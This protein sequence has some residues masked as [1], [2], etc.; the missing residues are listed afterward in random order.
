MQRRAPVRARWRD[1][2][3][4][5]IGSA[6]AVAA[7]ACVVA[8]ARPWAGEPSGLPADSVGLIGPSGE[9]VGGPVSVGSPA[10][11]AYGDGSVWA[12]DSADGTLARIDPA[13][14]AVVQQI[15]VGSAPS[16]VAVT[17]PDAWVTNSGD[18]TVSRVSTVTDRVVDTIQVGNLPVAIAAGSGGVWV[19]NEGDDT[20][21][22]IDPATGDV[23]KR[24][25]QVGAR[26]DGIAAGPDAVWVANGEDGTVQRIDPATGQPG[27]PVHV[28]SGPEGIAVTPGAVWVANSLDLTV[29]KLDPATGTVT[30]TIGVG[31]GPSSIVAAGNSLWVSDEFDATL[32]RIDP[33]AAPGRPHGSPGKLAAGHGGGRV[34]RMGRRAAVHRGQPPRRHLDRRGLRICLQTDPALA[35]DFIDFELFTAY[36]GLTAFRRSGGAA[37]LT[38]VP[39]LATTLP[40]PTAGGTTYTFT[41]RRG[42]RYSNGNLVRAS[43]FRR[44]IQRQL[45][46]GNHPDYYEGILGGSACRQHPKRCD[47]SAGI[48]TD[49]AAGRVTFRL[50]QADPDFLYKLA[51]INVSPAPPGTPD[52]AISRAPFL[53]G[54]GPYMISQVRPNKSFTLVRN[55]YFRQWSYAAQPAGYPSVIRHE[56]VDSQSAQESAVIAGRG[57]LAYLESSDLQSLAIRYPARV[58]FGLKNGTQYASLNTRQPPFTNLK[59]RQAVNYAIDRARILQL[60]HFASGQATVTC[61]M[62]P[63]DFPG[64]QG[65]CPYTTGA[66]DGAWHGPD[67]EKARRLVRE[68]GTMNMP[69]TV[70]S[71]DDRL[72]KAAGSYLVGL[73]DDLGYRARLHAVSPDQFCTDIYNP[74]LTIQVSILGGWGADY[75]APSTFFGPLLSCQSAD[76]PGTQNLAR[77]CDPHVDAL[78]SQAQAAQL[79]DPAAARRLW[80]QADHIVTD[81]APYVPVLN[82]GTAGFVS[83]RVGNYQESPVYGLL[84]DQMWVR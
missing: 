46:F 18:G 33:Q 58:Y 1:R 50:V 78:A 51:L 39:D 29:S 68:S 63:P 52:R 57:D 77:F 76:E 60:F 27:G 74:R 31:D 49:D 3:L 54:T 75:P 66:G 15:P 72:G 34:R 5:V 47:L 38:L 28:G 25:I 24:G 84:V 73:L 7:A 11:L 44:G 69:V 45:S 53:P 37:G 16:A 67:M 13:T 6:L 21:D 2:R 61:Q 35:D 71:Q 20:V 56:Q 64:H 80:A 12:V 36:D 62:L 48:V 41:L 19:A 9:R 26:P 42:I 30:A 43:D 70:W 81:Q 40:R 23:T 4:L 59:A 17:G 32:D 22:R 82:V 8:V 10:G 83:S 14:H 65:Y 55:P 79:T